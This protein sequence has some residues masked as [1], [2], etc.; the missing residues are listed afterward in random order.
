MLEFQS[1]RQPRRSYRELVADGQAETE[2]ALRCSNCGALVDPSRAPG[3]ATAGPALPPR[4]DRAA[5]ARQLEATATRLAEAL[6]DALPPAAWEVWV[7][8]LTLVDATSAE[9]FLAAPEHLA[10]WAAERYGPFL[11]RHATALAG[12][13]LTALV[14]PVALP[15][16]ATRTLGDLMEASPAGD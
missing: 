11:D 12:R 5:R 9:L 3:A 4:P 8:P 13:P 14:L 10:G 16:G 1:D 7:A 2:H 15:D 6:R